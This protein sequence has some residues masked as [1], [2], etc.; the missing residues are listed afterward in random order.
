MLFAHHH[1]V[2]DKTEEFLIALNLPF[3][4]I[5]GSTAAE[6]RYS[7]CEAFQNNVNIRVGILG[8]TAAGI[9]LTLTAASTIFFLELYW[10]PGAMLQAED[11][12]HRIGQLRDVKIFYFF[13]EDTVDELLWPLIRKKMQ[14]LGKLFLSNY[15]IL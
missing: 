12:V 14:L 15:Y 2:L 3:I 7:Q 8:I 5:D 13:G 1:D 6:T 11:R 10:T 9:A 4:R